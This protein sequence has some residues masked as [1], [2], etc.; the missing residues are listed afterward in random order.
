M[1]AAEKVQDVVTQSINAYKKDCSCAIRKLT[2][3]RN[4]DHDIVVTI[5]TDRGPF[6]YIFQRGS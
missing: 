6:R 3:E 4:K 2:V 1:I 5:F